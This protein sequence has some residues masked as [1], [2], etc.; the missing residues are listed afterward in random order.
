ML[1]TESR[2]ANLINSY[3]NVKNIT[4]QYTLI[5]IKFFNDL[6]ILHPSIVKCPA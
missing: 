2:L 1:E 5:V 3:R 4:M 6:D